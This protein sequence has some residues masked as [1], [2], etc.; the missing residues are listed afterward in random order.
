M[1]EPENFVGLTNDEFLKQAMDVVEKAQSRA[2]TLRFLGGLAVYMHSLD[3]NDS[4][5]AFKSLGRLGEGRPMFTDLDLIGYNKQRKG[6]IKVLQDLGFRPMSMANWWFGD[7]R[8]IYY[9]PVGKYQVDLFLSK[10]HFSH[11]VFFGEDA[12]K[13]R[14]ELDYPTITLED[15]VLEKLQIN[16]INRK[17]VIDLIVL[18]LGH[19]V[20]EKSDKN[21]VDAGY[22][23]KILSDDWG[24]WYDANKNLD[25]VRKLT[26]EL[27]EVQTGGL[28]KEQSVIVIERVHR[29]SKMIED[30]PKTENWAKRAKTGTSKPWYREVG[31]V[32]R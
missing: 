23:S 3:N 10:L 22:I 1:A 26:T 29:L 15:I 9:H 18:L 27:T 31:E 24:F 8:L 2:V 13:G 16:Q 21:Y 17:D 32:I 28:T 12:G 30:V 6:A 4:I 19:D 5:T 20:K 14:L 11:D 25:L 7:D